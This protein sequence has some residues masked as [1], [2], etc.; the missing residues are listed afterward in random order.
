MAIFELNNSFF[1]SI[2]KF[3]FI[4]KSLSDRSVKKYDVF[5]TRAWLK[6]GMHLQN[7]TCSKTHLDGITHKHAD[8]HFKADICSSSCGS[9]PAYNE[10]KNERNDKFCYCM[11]ESIYFNVIG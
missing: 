6:F 4:F 1:H 10:E 3:V 11:K 7:V 2:T 9:R 5:H 8:F